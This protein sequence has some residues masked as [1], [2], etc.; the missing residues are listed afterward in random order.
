MPFIGVSFGLLEHR[1]RM[2][3]AWWLYFFLHTRA[4]F[5]NPSGEVAFTFDEAAEALDVT[6]RTL[7][8]WYGRLKQQGYIRPIGDDSGREKI[9]TITK[10]KSVPLMAGGGK[11]LPGG[12]KNLPP[13]P[14]GIFR[15]SFI[16]K[17]YRTNTLKGWLDAI[18]DAIDEARNPIAELRTV[19]SL[20]WGQDNTPDFG[21]LGRAAKRAGNGQSRPGARVLAVRSVVAAVGRRVVGNPIDY[22]EKMGGVGA[23]ARPSRRGVPAPESRPDRWADPDRHG[24]WAEFVLVAG[25]KGD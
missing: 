7:R 4:E 20:I 3:P 12:G 14:E 13:K 5:R 21:R 18:L 23:N 22:V 24:D 8:A 9:I 19:F 15:P 6:K 16:Y 11:N 1:K 2:G 10:Y 17:D 25:G